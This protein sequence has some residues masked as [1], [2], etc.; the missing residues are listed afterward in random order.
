MNVRRNLPVRRFLLVLDMA[1]S[2]KR[3]PTY[4]RH[5]L[6]LSKYFYKSRVIKKGFDRSVY[7]YRKSNGE[8]KRID[9]K[10]GPESLV[11]DVGG[12]RG[13]FASEIYE[14]YKCQIWIFEPVLSFHNFME[15][16]FKENE[17]IRLFNLGLDRETRTTSISM[18]MDRSS[19]ERDL[20]EE[21]FEEVHL[22]NVVEFIKENS[23]LHIDLMKINI[24]GAEYELLDKLLESELHKIITNIQIQFHDFVPFAKAR[25][26]AIR[27]KLAETHILCWDYPFVWE[28]WEI[29]QN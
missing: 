24:E 17:K 15:S 14:R 28:S 2:I 8:S 16:R 26:D 1:F 5:L 10:L 23:V 13:D 7:L 6:G 25:R 3:T 9:Y 22:K 4:F 18:G 20:G 12:Y 19:Y 21:K 27:E 11:F 29:K